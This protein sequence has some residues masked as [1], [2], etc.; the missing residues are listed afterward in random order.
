MADVRLTRHKGE[1]LADAGTLVNVTKQ[2][3]EVAMDGLG[4][5]ASAVVKLT[6]HKGEVL[7]SILK[8]VDVTKQSV[9]VAMDGLGPNASGLVLLT[10]HKGEVL[11]SIL[12]KVEVPKQ[13]V[14]VAM[15]GLQSNP[16]AVV[17]L[18]RLKGEVLATAVPVIIVPLSDP[19]GL[20]LF[21]HN[22]ASR[23]EMTTAYLTDISPAQDSIAEERRM[24]V[25]RP[26]RTIRF[27]WTQNDEEFV[28]KLL[29][30][31]RRYPNERLTVPL[32]QDQMELTQSSAASATVFC[33]TSRSRVYQGQ[34]V[35]IVKIMHGD[36]SRID[37][38]DFRRVLSKQDDSLNLDSATSFAL[39][40]QDT[41]V[42]PMIDVEVNLQSNVQFHAETVGD[43][44][45][46]VEEVVGQSAL[47]SSASGKPD[48]F[49]E[50][51]GRPIFSVD[52]NWEE[53]FDT[54][55]LREGLH[56]ARGRGFVVEPRGDRHRTIFSFKFGPADR[57]DFWKLLN[58]FDTR[59]GRCRSFWAIDQENN[60]KV[61][62]VTGGTL[63]D[64][65]PLGD[66]AAFQQE[67]EY[68]GFVL[69]D[70]T[71]VVREAV[72]IVD[73][74]TVWRV[75]V[76]EAVSFDEVDVRRAARARLVRFKEDELREAWDHT[77]AV[78]A[79]FE[80]IEVLEEKDVTL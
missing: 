53:P 16:N 63:I 44:P 30:Q 14:E 54:R 21:L 66:F 67:M 39:D 26:F 64:F 27:R 19:V 48:G 5:N 65:E 37:L 29:V 56:T 9:E 46:Q 61:V 41:I 69:E 2:S 77:G 45:L 38:V 32:Y 36:Q 20:K 1:V 79:E 25:A 49:D 73:I 13:S 7:A 47:P 50:Y 59:R 23:V 34:R 8:Q 80:L 42:F 11:A 24:L 28:D 10:R 18:T 55:F 12:K 57:D 74:S 51:R 35:A 15:S 70:G 60:W 43:V 71:R 76:P 6:R 40:V 75:T 3:T 33:D 52:H 68:I 78:T 31:L 22:W 58:F 17:R 72:T 4:A 62:N